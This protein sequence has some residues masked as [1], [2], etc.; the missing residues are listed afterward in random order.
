M[1]F[2]I[3]S[4]PQVYLSAGPVK[5]LLLS[6]QVYLS[7]GPVKFLIL[8]YY[9][10]KFLFLIPY[11]FYDYYDKKNHYFLLDYCYAGNLVL[12]LYIWVFPDSEFLWVVS[13]M[14]AAGPLIWAVAMF[15]NALVFLLS[16]GA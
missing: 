8:Y 7:A 5:F 14:S 11:R 4:S 6:P 3:L 9:T 12:F 15:R 2:L 1:K 10:L 13:F 16:R